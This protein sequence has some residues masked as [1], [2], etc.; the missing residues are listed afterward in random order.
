MNESMYGKVGEQRNMSALEKKV[1]A[2]L[3][4]CTAES[5]EVRRK[6][7]IGLLQLMI[8]RDAASEA[9]NRRERID[10]ILSDL[11]IP[12]HLYG[13]KFLQT[14]IELSLEDPK[15]IYSMTYGLYP[16]VAERHNT[17]PYSV[18]RGIR[19]A[20]VCGWTRCD[21]DMQEK[22]FGGTVNPKR[23]KPTNTEFIA[24]ICNIIN[25]PCS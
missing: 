4:F 17:H 14:A 2:L 18:E 3:H 6:Y 20:I 16:A 5:E 8:G 7:H 12:D 24:R 9:E 25:R 15:L 19:N 23:C 22:Y 10:R 11:G 21:L 13:Y 1:D